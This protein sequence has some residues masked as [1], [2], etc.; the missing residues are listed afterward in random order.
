MVR[1]VPV[2]ELKAH[3]AEVLRDVEAGGR[4]VVERR[5]KPVAVLV[6]HDDTNTEGQEWWRELNGIAADVPDLDEIMRDV[7][8]SRQK[9]KPRPVDLED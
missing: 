6:P 9:A 7:M 8:R 5:G 2:A 4:V 1:K 3:L